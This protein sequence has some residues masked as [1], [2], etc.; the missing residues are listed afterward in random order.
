ME[1]YSRLK[2]FEELSQGL[3][4]MWQAG[5]FTDVEVMVD[6]HSYHCHRL[7]LGAMSDY[8]N[9]MFSSGFKESNEKRVILQ[10]VDKETF[11]MIL[12]FLYTGEDQ[13]NNDN[14]SQL[15]MASVMLQIT[16]LQTICENF[17]RQNLN[18]YNC[19][20]VWR[21]ANAHGLQHLTK[22]SWTFIMKFFPE[23]CGEEEFD[24]MT[25]EELTEIID[26]KD[27]YTSSEELVC[28]AVIKW[29]KSDVE[30]RACHM[31][32]IFG[33][34]RLSLMDSDYLKKLL[35][36]DVIRECECEKMVQD[37]LDK[38]SEDEDGTEVSD[39][40]EEEVI[41][42][43]GTRSRNPDP[44]KTEIQCYSYRHRKTFT[45]MDL[46]KETGPC[47]AVC[48]DGKDIFISGGYVE[49]KI[50]LHFIAK[51]NKW[52]ES[53]MN[54][55][56]WSH[57]MAACGESVYLIGGMSHTNATMS[58]IEKFDINQNSCTKVGD[59]Q[60]PVS[61]LTLAVLGKRIYT[62]GGKH[63]NRQPATVIQCYDTQTGACAVIGDL[64]SSCAGSVGRAVRYEDRVYLILREG[65]IVEFQNHCATQVC[66]ITKFDHFG[67]VEFEGRI[68]I[69]GTL[70]GKLSMFIFDPQSNEVEESHVLFKAAMCNFHCLK[71]VLSKK[72]LI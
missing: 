46:P 53:C 38:S 63:S 58:C 54:E 44:Q 4:S 67:A 21:I 41:C 29:V 40:R 55:G 10:G 69:V 71:M 11:E 51:E 48:T 16:S 42:M 3:V 62:F 1:M 12:S 19:V 15:L 52:V 30:A 20:G 65:Q 32:E 27:L 2:Y 24:G 39:Y 64:P 56:R 6:E 23:I 8:F 61:S 72:F 45:L 31:K 33:H 59:L 35:V 36:M 50:V 60:V 34:L 57:A 9:A 68:L 43:V 70:S 25:A 14:V 17:L 37:I 47:F 22:T 28:D 13:I 49:R 18:I 7:V 26:N 66:G 5:C